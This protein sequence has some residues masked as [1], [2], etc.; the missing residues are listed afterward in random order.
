[1][2]S[3]RCVQRNGAPATAAV[4]ADTIAAVDV[5]LVADD[6]VSATRRLVETIRGAGH[7]LRVAPRVGDAE[8]VL[9]VGRVDAV[10]IDATV[11]EPGL[12]T[13]V[14]R[15]AP[16]APV[17]A[18][19]PT[20][21][22]GGAADWLEAGAD[23]ALHAGMGER[24]LLARVAALGRRGAGRTAV[25][26]VGP[27]CVD[28]ERGEA[29]WQ[30]R[31]LPLSARERALLHALALTPQATVRRESLYRQVWG[32]SM[33]RGDRAVDVNVKRLRDKL[34]AAVGPP[35]VVETEPGVGYRLLVSESAVTAL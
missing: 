17:A 31:R 1:M 19:L 34:A 29:S 26:A 15:W 5:V 23:E 8:L 2:P 32:Y 14:R 22:S 30:G 28:E 11:A 6:A 18:W 21:S 4:L 24:E 7:V 35:L 13:L 10:L 20:A 27:L 33:P 9:R 16:V 3:E 25:V 12:L